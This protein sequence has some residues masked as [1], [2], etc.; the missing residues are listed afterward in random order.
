MPH[1]CSICS[2]DAANIV[3]EM[4]WEKRTLDEIASA[5]N[6]NRS[7]I[8]RHGSPKAKCKFSFTAYKAARVKAK[9]KGVDF[10]KARVVVCWPNG[11]LTF[12]D[13][14]R[15]LTREDV[16][17]GD[18]VLNVKFEERKHRDMPNPTDKAWD[19]ALAEDAERSLAKAE[20]FEV[21]LD[22]VLDPKTS[23]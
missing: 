15:P 18:V 9:N 7:S 22:D 23:Q 5:T 19:E 20:I 4:L 11:K 10:S 3:N 14:A 16:Q 13:N 8:H 17:P 12:M 21:N 1:E 6:F 2:K